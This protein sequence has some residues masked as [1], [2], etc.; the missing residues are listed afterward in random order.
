MAFFNF[1]Y[2]VNAIKAN[3]AANANRY[4]GPVD[5]GGINNISQ[6]MGD[7]VGAEVL[8]LNALGT[9]FQFV[10]GSHLWGS[11]QYKVSA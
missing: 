9:N 4:I 7:I 11:Q 8:R 2:A 1:G 6:D 5:T 10:F 3:N